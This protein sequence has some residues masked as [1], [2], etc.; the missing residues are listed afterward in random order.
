MK[1]TKQ[2]L[3]LV[4]ALAM[5][6]SYAVKA[7]TIHKLY[8]RPETSSM[9]ELK[10]GEKALAAGNLEKADAH[11]MEAIKLMKVNYQAYAYI[12]IIEARKGDLKTAQMRFQESLRMFEPHKTLLLERLTQ[13]IRAFETNVGN[14]RLAVDRAH[15]PGGAENASGVEAKY[16][17]RKN[18]INSYNKEYSKLKEMKYPAF[19][20]FK[21]G[22]VLLA[23]G[24][25]MAAKSQYL[26]AV[27]SDPSFKD[28][29][30]NLA[31][32]WF[33]EGN[34]KEAVKAYKKAKELKAEV[35]PDF[36]AELKKKCGAE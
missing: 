9:N 22:N 11:F 19:F 20:H 5:V 23:A 35:N 33:M 18:I 26:S 24:H 13:Y 29:Y 16:S 8:N 25:E 31:V 17:S 27:E 30:G 10:K 15:S 34:C 6:I 3:L 14:S 2:T 4:M 32:C 36:E 12:G 1:Q 7:Q 21:Y 28:T